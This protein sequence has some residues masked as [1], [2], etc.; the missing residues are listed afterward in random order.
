[1]KTKGCARALLVAITEAMTL[2][3]DWPSS[4]RYIQLARTAELYRHLNDQLETNKTQRSKIVYCYRAAQWTELESANMEE[5][6]VT[7]QFNMQRHNAV[8][9]RYGN[10]I[11]SSYNKLT[12]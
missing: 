4:T 1:M 5:T 2:L 8:Q 9:E 12:K 11:T 3:L 10:K 7:W 6:T